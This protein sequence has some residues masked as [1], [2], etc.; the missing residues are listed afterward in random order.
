MLVVLATFVAILAG[1]GI[2]S[3]FRASPDAPYGHAVA[4]PPGALAPPATVALAPYALPAATILMPAPHRPK[5][6]L[7]LVGQANR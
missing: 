2:G 4:V 6:G 7:E 3:R 1:Y 5:A